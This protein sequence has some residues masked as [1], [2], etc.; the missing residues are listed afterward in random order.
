VVGN[1][2]KTGAQETTEMGDTELKHEGIKKKTPV[3]GRPARRG[4]SAGKRWTEKSRGLEQ[5]LRRTAPEHHRLIAK[6]EKNGKAGGEA[7]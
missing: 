6:G 2:K 1:K 3:I 5:N 7:A 4:K